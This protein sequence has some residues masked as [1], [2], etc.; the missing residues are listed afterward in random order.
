MRTDP[1]IS[2]LLGLPFWA[3]LPVAFRSDMAQGAALAALAWSMMLLTGLLLRRLKPFPAVMI[4][5]AAP[6]LLPFLPLPVALTL[7]AVLVIL[8][9]WSSS[10]DFRRRGAT[11]AAASVPPLMVLS[12]SVMA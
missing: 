5:A 10:A 6:L 2:L 12:A 1:A 9:A 11:L 4:L 7:S 8:C 3:L